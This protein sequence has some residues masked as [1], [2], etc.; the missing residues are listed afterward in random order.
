MYALVNDIES[1][2]DFLPWCTSAEVHNR[3]EIHLLATVGIAAGK[4][5]Q[6]FTTENT[7]RPGHFIHMQLVEGPFK[8]LRGEWTFQNISEGT[9]VISL[10]IDFE[11][12]SKILKLAL[13][14]TFNRIMD[15]MVDSFSKRAR[16]IY[17]HR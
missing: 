16:E 1:Y 14:G 6:K 11:F 17:G 13:S 7:M 15:S 9:S 8:F 3:S 10:S 5:R 4:V 12:K 2:P